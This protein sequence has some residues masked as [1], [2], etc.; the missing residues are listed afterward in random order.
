MAKLI[1]DENSLTIGDLEDFEDAIGES[2]TKALKPVAVRDDEGNI[3]RDDKGRPEETVDMSA[4]VLK[5]LIWI[6]QRQDDPD[7]TLADARN[8]KVTELDIVRA[9]EDGDSDSKSGTSDPKD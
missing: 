2:L 8:V 4:K 6:A 9:E 7:F 1:F 5:G 3:V